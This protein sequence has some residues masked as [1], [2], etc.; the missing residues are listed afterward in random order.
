MLICMYA[1]LT[2]HCRR[3]WKVRRLR[4]QWICFDILRN[5]LWLGRLCDQSRTYDVLSSGY[6]YPG[7]HLAKGI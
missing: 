4:A 3:V 7:C 6:S 5:E 1:H 2:R